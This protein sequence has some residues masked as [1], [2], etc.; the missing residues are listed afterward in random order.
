MQ[1]VSHGVSAVIKNIESTFRMSSHT[2]GKEKKCHLRPQHQV[3]RVMM[4]CSRRHVG[5][6]TTAFLLNGKTSFASHPRSSLHLHVLWQGH[7][8]SLEAAESLSG[9]CGRFRAVVD[10]ACLVNSKA[11]LP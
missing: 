10:V 4:Q 8:C 7:A 2:E 6:C 3:R 11:H 5:D 1:H 9:K